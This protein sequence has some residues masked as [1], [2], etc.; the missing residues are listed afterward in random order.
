MISEEVAF[1]TT[2]LRQNEGEPMNLIDQFNLP[3]INALWRITAGVRFQYDDC[4]LLEIMEG[5]STIFRKMTS[6]GNVICYA[7]PW[8]VQIG[9][10]KEKLGRQ[11]FVQ[12][13]RAVIDMMRESVADHKASIDTNEP[14][15]FIDMMLIE[16]HKSENPQSSFYKEKG[17][18]NLVNTLYD[19]FLAGSETTSTSLSWA[20][21]YMKR[22]PEVQ[23]KM[24]TELDQ[25]IGNNRAAAMKDKADLPY[26]QAVIMEIQRMANIGFTLPENTLVQALY[27]EILKGDQ[28]IDG[29]SFRPERFLD[30]EGNVVRKEQFIPFSIGKRYCLGES[31]AKAELFLFFTGLIQQFTLSPQI[32]G[33]IPSE[34]YQPGA[35]IIPQP[36]H[37]RLKSRI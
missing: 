11:Q 3:I 25:V 13:S 28:W 36:F 20:V 16:I 37:V 15:D 34:E 7:Y 33:Q 2:S 18:E 31:L 35:T 10:M 27:A 17:E 26:T 30:G 4:K 21:L 19:L 24:Q 22:N 8:L 23:E 32:P 12:N 1:F 9:W 29:T 14:R 6:P 5:L